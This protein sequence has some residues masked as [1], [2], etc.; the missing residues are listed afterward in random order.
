[1]KA[2]AKKSTA[3]K[4]HGTLLKS[5]FSGLHDVANNTGLSL[6]LHSFSCCCLPNLRN[7]AKFSENSDS[8][9]FNVIQGHRSWY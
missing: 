6:Y 4:K 7:P 8:W 9:Q 3:N 2:P 5:T 1:M